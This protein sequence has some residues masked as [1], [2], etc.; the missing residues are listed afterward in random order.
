MFD[1]LIIVIHDVAEDTMT[2]RRLE[3]IIKVSKALGYR[4]VS[5]DDI[6]ND[7]EKGKKIALTVDDA[8]KSCITTTLPILEKYDIKATLFV[9]PGLLG[10]EANHPLLQ[11]NDCYP[12][13][14]I[15]TW[16]ELRQWRNN[17]H[18]VGFHTNNHI[19][20]HY[21]SDETIMTDFLTGL[22]A[23]SNNGFEIKYFAYPKG[24]LPKNRPLIENLFRK[25]GIQYAFTINRGTVNPQNAFYIYRTTLGNK[26]R[27]F[28]TMFKIFGLEDFY[29]YNIKKQYREAKI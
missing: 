13:K 18:S 29:F 19:D 25:N 26:E 14:G 23:L 27:F 8:Y 15:I 16:D 24:F 2:P 7:Q 22:Q 6:L 1:K 12:N 20:M 17:G 5:L 3:K 21:N 11:S 28:W 9:S 4:F 10:L